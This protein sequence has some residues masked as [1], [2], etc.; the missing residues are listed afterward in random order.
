MGA[1]AVADGLIMT[2]IGAILNS[3]EMGDIKCI[4][5]ICDEGHRIHIQR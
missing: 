2:E 3:I 1:G 5:F 4:E